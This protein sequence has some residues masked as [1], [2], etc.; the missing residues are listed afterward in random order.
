M[1]QRMSMSPKASSPA[2]ST[3]SA[4]KVKVTTSKHMSK[5]QKEFKQKTMMIMQALDALRTVSSRLDDHKGQALRADNGAIITKSQIRSYQAALKKEIYKLNSYFVS[6][7]RSTR[8]GKMTAAE[9]RQAVTAHVNSVSREIMDTLPAP[10]SNAVVAGFQT[11][12]QTEV[13]EFILKKNGPKPIANLNYISD[14]LAGFYAAADFGRGYG[15]SDFK[16][17]ISPL[18]VTGHVT[19]LSI[20]MSLMS[21]YIARNGLKA[22]KGM[23]VVSDLMRQYFGNG[24]DTVLRIN[25]NVL[26]TSAAKLGSI[27][28]T[29]LSGLARL[30]RAVGMDVTQMMPRKNSLSLTTY[31]RVPPEV[32]NVKASADYATLLK[33]AQAIQIYVK[34]TSAES[35]DAAKTSKKVKRAA[36]AAELAALQAAEETA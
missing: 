5:L 30:S 31:Y 29:E 34:L 36:K 2:S 7:L 17:V 35:D 15:G 21:L 1:S 8:K 6:A 4:S 10:V 19:A 27:V 3:V 23:F 18:V 12:M 28:N 26:D 22:D 13:N 11:L 9:V 24:T 33:T 16:T 14:Q 25:G 32:V 20:N